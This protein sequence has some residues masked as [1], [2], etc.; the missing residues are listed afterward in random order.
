M[1][2]IE[3]L[4]EYTKDLA[5][6]D[7]RWINDMRT[8]NLS[9][10]ADMKIPT[11]KDE[12]WKYTNIAP[13]LKRRYHFPAKKES[14]DQSQLKKY[15][16]Q[17]EINIV[18][19]NGIFAPELSNHTDQNAL[20]HG[21]HISTF[22]DAINN[23]DAAIKA[24]LEKSTLRKDLP[25]VALNQTLTHDGAYIQISD[26]TICNTLIHIL[27]ITNFTGAEIITTPRS[28]ITLGESSEAMILESHLAFSDELTY[29]TDSLNELF[30]GENAALHYCKAQAESQKAFHIGA[31]YVSQARDSNFNGF[32]MITKG[33]MTRNN[34]N[35]VL[36]GEGANTILN[37]FYALNGKQH[38]DN[39]TSIDHRVPNCTS[40][41]L[42]KG[43]LNGQ[44][45]AVFNGKILVRSVA[46]QTN[47]YQLNKNLIL[48]DDCRVDTKP[49][50]EIFA[51]NVKCSHGATIGQINEDELFYLQSRSI[52][53]RAAIKMLAWGFAND[54]LSAPSSAAFSRKLHILFEPMVAQLG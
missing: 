47:S 15:C 3:G 12:E 11:T 35:I 16:R 4:E 14:V 39:H 45:R 43:I 42:Y 19:V 54:I 6:Q 29:F 18:F 38:A 31:T 44:S 52:S 46:Q 37:G 20:P 5:R 28:L 53:H 49:Q 36:E 27:H 41:Q 30:L 24:F 48:G 34:V 22:Q 9:Q 13:V 7:P 10:W 17:D 25:F 50:L 21:V 32:S 8:K 2:F 40:N 33:A 51:D 26:K 1:S 23:D